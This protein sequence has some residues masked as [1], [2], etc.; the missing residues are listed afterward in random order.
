MPHLAQTKETH[1]DHLDRLMRE[2][3]HGRDVNVDARHTVESMWDMC[4]EQYN[5]DQKGGR[6]PNSNYQYTT[7]NRTQGAVNTTIANMTRRDHT[8]EFSPEDALDD[9]VYYVARNLNR[10]IERGEVNPDDFGLTEQ[11]INA[12]EPITYPQVQLIFDAL[13]APNPQEK[14]E[15]VVTAVTDSVVA[16][17]LNKV[18]R[19]MTANKQKFVKQLIRN[20][21]ILGTGFLNF[22]Y[23]TKTHSFE[24]YNWPL[25]QVWIDPT[26][27][28]IDE[29]E[30]FQ[31]EYPIS[32]HLA[33]K[34]WPKSAAALKRNVA[35]GRSNSSRQSSNF[36]KE[37][38]KHFPGYGAQYDSVI[39]ERDMV[40]VRIAYERGHTFPMR[41]NE[42][43][44]EGLIAR[45]PV[46]NVD[47]EGN[48]V[49]SDVFV[50]LDEDGAALQPVEQ[51]GKDWPTVDGIRMT[52]FLPQTD[53]ILFD[54]RCPYLDI[55]VGHAKNVE[56]VGTPYGQGE[57]FRLEP[58]QT[59]VNKRATD[60]A[61]YSQSFR[62]PQ[63]IMPQ[64]VIAE[65]EAKGIKPNQSPNT[66]LGVDDDMYEEVFGR[67]NRNSF[68]VQPPTMPSHMVELLGIFLSEMDRTGGNIDVL[69]GRAPG[70]G[71]SGRSIL[72]LQQEGK[73]PIAYKALNIKE[74]LVR[75]AL[76]EVDALVRFLPPLKWE[77]ILGSFDKGVIS[78][79][80]ERIKSIRWD[81]SV[82]L[83]DGSTEDVNKELAMALFERAALDVETLLETVKVADPRKV[84]KRLKKQSEQGIQA[85]P[86]PGDLGKF[87]PPP[88]Q[89]VGGQDQTGA[90]GTNA[91]ANTPDQQV[92]LTANEQAQKQP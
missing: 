58:L 72:A 92:Q 42:A 81:V 41:V 56:M 5:G 4:V 36:P 1:I 40:I 34:K 22:E 76:I 65:F 19:K 18:Y 45:Q 83:P 35:S 59:Q 68:A 17:A 71:S 85:G 25:R 60:L 79:I 24:Y 26:K 44:E 64:S 82:T 51:D 39:F 8:V 91:Q 23:N 32:L 54:G 53:D 77:R 33:L 9:P 78:A 11:Q 27:E 7:V 20:T 38:G 50:L 90:T 15:N 3:K 43:I 66:V 63:Q 16:D 49:E 47:G 21:A 86:T 28:G 46:V 12:E 29:S 31:V 61:T 55:N 13:L 75:M 74:M 52:V 10:A 87:A 69:Q 2:A 48:E 88:P 62:S 84:L 57:P 80:V 30:H 70:S 67:G 37:G 6:G 14:E 73:A 89:N